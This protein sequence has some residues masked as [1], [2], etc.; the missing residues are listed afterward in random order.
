MVYL[1]LEFGGSR[2][3][4]SERKRLGGRIPFDILLPWI[5]QLCDVLTYLHAQNPSIVHRDLKPGNI[6]LDDSDRIMLIDFG[7]AKESKVSEETRTIARAASQGFSPPEQ[8]LGT[9]TDQRSDI[10]ALAATLYAMLTGKVPLAVEKRFSGK[11]LVP[12]SQLVDGIPPMVD[13]AIVQALD[14]NADLRPQ[15]VQAFSRMLEKAEGGAASD[16]ASID[17]TVRLKGPT[18]DSGAT[19]KDSGEASWQLVEMEKVEDRYTC[20]ACGHV[21]KKAED[22]SDI[23]DQCGV[24]GNKHAEAKRRKDR[25]RS[26]G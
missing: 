5:R 18:I 13:K 19:A 21:Q 15:T 11:G 3:L 9:G 22:E 8:V 1:V 25:N 16:P 12:P 20:P 6:L 26:R 10:Y 23:C 7:I 24:I 17:K 2:T 14:L 4:G